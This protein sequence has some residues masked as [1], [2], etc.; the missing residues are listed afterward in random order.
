[1]YERSEKPHSEVPPKKKQGAL[2]V[3]APGTLQSWSVLQAQ[4]KGL[5]RSPSTF[6]IS[7][8]GRQTQGGAATHKAGHCRARGQAAAPRQQRLHQP[9]LTAPT[10]VE[11]GSAFTA[12]Q[13]QQRNPSRTTHSPSGLTLRE[14]DKIPSQLSESLT[15]PF[16][17]TMNRCRSCRHIEGQLHEE[18]IVKRLR[19]P[20]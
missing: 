1:M 3:G 19:L 18:F 12:S 9:C 7:L 20:L 16:P 5:R 6:S 14:G 2:M 10:S 11:P 4:L 15:W 8:N 13:E 17:T